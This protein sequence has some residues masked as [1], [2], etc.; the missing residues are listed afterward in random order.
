[1]IDASRVISGMFLRVHG[2]ATGVPMSRTPGQL[3]Y[4]VN[5]IIGMVANDEL[6]LVINIARIEQIDGIFR[7][8]VLGLSST[9]LLG[10]AYLNLF[11]AA[12]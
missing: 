8:E 6:V 3:E 5:P 12:P 9:G 7:D 4:D 10:W 2:R 11:E 1:M